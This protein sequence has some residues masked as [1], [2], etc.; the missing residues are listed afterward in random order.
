MLQLNYVLEVF[1][2]HI[3]QLFI[4]NK[5]EKDLVQVKNVG[6]LEQ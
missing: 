6:Y 2:L 1:L 5:L 4:K 3:N